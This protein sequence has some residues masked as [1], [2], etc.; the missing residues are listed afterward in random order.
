MPKKPA[1]KGA[2][3]HL[4]KFKIISRKPAVNAAL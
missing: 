4:L 2:S 3:W 1:H